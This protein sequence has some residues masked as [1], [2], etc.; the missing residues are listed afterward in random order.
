MQTQ[1]F[2]SAGCP[3]LDDMRNGRRWSARAGIAL[4]IGL[5]WEWAG[6]RAPG[7]LPAPSE[8]LETL[9]LPGPRADPLARQLPGDIWQTLVRMLIGTALGFATGIPIGIA[10]AKL[11]VARWAVTPYLTMLNTVP[12]I[13][14]LPVLV[15]VLGFG[16]LPALV[17]VWSGVVVIVVVNTRTA[18]MGVDRVLLDRLRSLNARRRDTVRFLLWPT[19]V[20]ALVGTSR[21]AIGY[22]WALA[23]L[24]ETFGQ[25]SGVGFLLVWYSQQGF[26]PGLFLVALV[27]TVCAVA[28]ERA[29]AAVEH[30]LRHYWPAEAM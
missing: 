10:A 6:R 18:I 1:I 13:A 9:N 7:V 19:M 21:L 16:N 8:L 23:L 24:S 3:K 4:L 30:R 17:L 12:H 15:I 2:R 5:G 11:K 28:M 14:I 29:V 20:P 26:L 22:A 27:I 25:Q